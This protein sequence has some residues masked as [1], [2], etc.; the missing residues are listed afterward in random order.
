[1][2]QEKNK[3]QFSSINLKRA[4]GLKYILEHKQSIVY[5]NERL[6]GNFTSKRVGAPFY[7][8]MVGLIMIGDYYNPFTAYK[9]PLHFPILDRLKVFLKI[10]PHWIL[11]NVLTRTFIPN[12]KNPISIM[13][14]IKNLINYAVV[15]LNPKHYF[16][17]EIGGIIHLI[18]DYEGLLNKGIRGYLEE[19][20]SAYQTADNDEEKNFLQSLVVVADGIVKMASNFAV[21]A[22]R[23]A[24]TKEISKKRKEISKKRKE[25]LIEIAQVCRKVPYQPSE[26]FHE[27][28]QAIL[29]VHIALAQETLDMS[30]SFGRMD[31]YLYPLYLN[32]IKNYAEKKKINY[33]EAKAIIKH[34]VQELLEC[35]FLKT[36]EVLPLYNHLVSKAHEGLPSFYA[37][38]IGGLTP[39]GKDGEND[40]TRTFL[41]VIKKIPLR[42][43]N[44]HVR[45]SKISKPK[46]LDDVVTVIK[47]TGFTPAIIN[48]EAI[49]P[50]LQEHLQHSNNLS[51]NEALLEARNFGTIGC[52]EIGIPGKSYPMADAAFFN[53]PIC[54]VEA[55]T[56]EEY[57]KICNIEDLKK[58]FE[59][60]VQY[61][62]NKMIRELKLIEYARRNFFPLPLVSLMVNGCVAKATDI[63]SGGAQYNWSSIQAIGIADTIDSFAAIEKSLKEQISLETIR[64]SIKN[65][66]QNNEKLHQTLIDAPKFGQ[67]DMRADQYADFILNC[68]TSALK[69]A[70]KN[71]RGGSY[72]SGGFSSGAHQLFGKTTMALPSGRKKG[73][74]FANGVSPID[75][76]DSS[77][78]TA[79][80][81]SVS[82]LNP[83]Y[84]VNGYT[85]N[86][87]VDPPLMENAKLFAGLI[88]AFFKQ[89]N[90]GIQIQFNVINEKI[91]KEARIFPD[92]YP[93]LVVRVSGYSAYFKDL[94]P[95]MQDEIIQRSAK[96]L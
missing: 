54:I 75:A 11:R 87:K 40:L 69:N 35:F 84:Y 9:M 21:E 60:E 62:V 85:F 23:I 24:K 49:I 2:T 1:L 76:A 65:N 14:G 42:Q 15:Q 79:T 4:H 7:P 44:Y 61:H 29:F 89:N 68:Y 48:D 41:D 17:N 58:G 5:D 93:W 46:F 73:I 63:T 12:T 19:V 91:L 33:D 16:I 52:V 20:E 57:K 78:I 92:K 53:L 71:T 83:K 45:Y 13:K 50:T 88:R 56:K 74:R 72:I 28:L 26:T 95:Q 39:D 94:S 80:M 86:Q 10:F 37:V 59:K 47:K 36:N 8:E 32:E 31:Q 3:T 77:V 90:K 43:P 6:V 81:N 27:A 82:R 66:F 51:D 25:E 70:G 34:E 22:E 67:D 96:K 30:I 55:L 38:T 18:P 64:N